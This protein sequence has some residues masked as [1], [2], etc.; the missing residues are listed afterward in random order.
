MTLLNRNYPILKWAG[1]KS[2]SLEYLLDYFDPADV[3]VEPFL[4]S[5]AVFINTLY[6]RY[7]LADTNVDL[8]N[9]YCI[10]KEQPEKFIEELR[11]LWTLEMKNKEAYL[12]IRDEFNRE[13]FTKSVRR[14]AIF[15]YMNH[16]GFHGLCRYN[17]NG[18]FNV[19]FGSKSDKVHPLPEDKIMRFSE[20]SQK[21]DFYC[22]DFEKTLEMVPD[23]AVVYCDP[24]YAPLKPET[25][26]SYTKEDFD[27]SD[28]ARLHQAV[29]DL[30]N[31]RENVSAFIS[32][33]STDF[34]EGLYKDATAI[35]YLMVYRNIARQSDERKEVKELVAT[36]KK[37]G[38]S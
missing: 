23:N 5:G 11:P 31:R 16:F 15:M 26:S 9:T 13:P 30:V 28:H 7:I 36:F 25:F 21:A 10:V 34:V 8:I 12:E 4:G 29:V 17:S 32:N 18:F 14:S 1:G 37:A 24:P 20:L 6:P 27:L 19:P 33:H 38:K 3:F 2:R 22:Q 35:D